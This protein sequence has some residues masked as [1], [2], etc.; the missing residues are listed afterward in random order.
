P[1]AVREPNL[2]PCMGICL[3]HE[4]EVSDL[5]ILTATVT[6]NDARWNSG[7]SH[8]GHETGRVVL[9]KSKATMKKEF[10]EVVLSVFA[11]RKRIAK[12]LGTKKPQRFVY[13]RTWLRFFGRPRLRQCTH[14][15]IGVRGY[16]EQG[17]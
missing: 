17:L 13:D 5:V 9:A 11:R 6:G 2:A 8:K 12:A 4:K 10:L 7:Q 1:S 14:C 15:R 3:S 16:L